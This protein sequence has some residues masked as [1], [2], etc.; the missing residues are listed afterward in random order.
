MQIA[1]V[2]E[3]A[4]PLAPLGGV[5][6]GGQNV[7]VGELAAACARRGHDVTV[8]TRRDDSVTDTEVVTGA[9]YRVVHVPAGPPEPIPKD[10]ILPHLGD[11]AGFLR[12]RW[13]AEPPDIVHAHFWMSG[14]ASELA[15]RGLDIPVVLTFHALGSVKRRYQGAA[16]TSP[17]SRIKFERLIAARA[18]RIIA[19]SR[20]EVSELGRMGVPRGRVSVVPC[21]VD[22]ALFTPDGPAAPRGRRHRLVSIGRPVPRKGF[23]TAIRAL[24]HLPDT[25]LLIAGGCAGTEADMDTVSVNEP[26]HA[27]ILPADAPRVPES[28]EDVEMHRLRRIAAESGVADRVRLLGR[29]PRARMPELLRSADIVV[30]TPWYEP[31]GMVPLEAMACGVPVVAGAVGG[32]LDTVTADITGLHVAPQPAPVARAL[33]CLL[34]DPAR[35]QAMG[36]AGRRRACTHY[37]WDRVADDTLEI[38]RQAAPTRSAPVAAEP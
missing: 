27:A 34:E 35:R 30:C 2:S 9:G 33:A 21:G 1:M 23:D 3:H 10:D 4:N 16:D 22:L 36:A 32:M 24:R 19:T 26:D 7:H 18:D 31:F 13:S 15:V 29:V 37:S 25:E 5:D 38:Y 14:M 17:A 12:R 6:A 11:F 8:Y 28:N 20:D